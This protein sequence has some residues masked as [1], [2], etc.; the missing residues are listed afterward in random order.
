MPQ[1]AGAWHDKGHR[2]TAS[3]A[4]DH[5]SSDMRER[6]GR[7]LAVHPRFAEDFVAHRPAEFSEQAE[8]ES[9]RWYLEQA[10]TW[11]DLIQD[12][13][14]GIRQTWNRSRWHYI[15]VPIFLTP[16]DESALAGSLDHNM[17]TQYSPPLR[18]SLNIIQALRG[19]LAIWRDESTS[20]ADK[21]VAL[22]WILHLVGDL[23]QPLH[24][25]ALFSGAYFPKGDRGGNSIE[26][27]WGGDSRN[28]HSVWDSRPS[29]IDA[30]QSSSS[31]LWRLA[32]ERVDNDAIDRWLQRHVLLAKHYVYTGDVHKQ[33]LDG[34][35]REEFPTIELSAAYL[36]DAQV[37]A[38]Q[39]ILLSGKRIAKL[40]VQ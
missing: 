27:T 17:A 16:Q 1:T 31:T 9:L 8:D 35:T 29:S 25:V 22:C 40:L 33:L 26:V 18:Q 5:L 10:A 12:L 21:A 23:H 32:N 28:L 39:Q 6:I 2:A 4:F 14:E 37:L 38:E 24:T 30:F 20:D 7:I 3:I 13:D 15:N 19:N 11:P 36:A 34:L